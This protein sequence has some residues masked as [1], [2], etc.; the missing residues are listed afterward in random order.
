MD[1]TFVQ[2]QLMLQNNVECRAAWKLRFRTAR[3]ENRAESRGSSNA[4][5]DA[6]AFGS[7]GNGANPRARRG[8][9]SCSL[10][11][12]PFAARASD[13]SFRV[14]G[15]FSA[16]IRAARSG[17]QIDS[18]PIR[19]DQCI[20]SHAKF[21]APF[22]LARALGLDQLASKIRAHWNNDVI[23]L[24]D[25]ERSVEIKGIADLRTARGD[26]VFKNDSHMCTCGNSDQL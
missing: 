1:L 8:R 14:H 5:A 23:V 7:V 13:F 9:F 6:E 18:V 12:L 4:R 17:I 19:K 24:R 10:Y 26:A 22:H 11:V 25:W 15:L 20:Q 3:Q 2:S 21:T 16:S